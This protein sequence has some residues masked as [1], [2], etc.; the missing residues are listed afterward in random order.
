M[1]ITIFYFKIIINK[2]VYKKKLKHSIVRQH[3]ETF[4][5][6]K[7]SYIHFLYIVI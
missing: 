1:I 3:N 6:K 2:H 7:N 5:I 4:F